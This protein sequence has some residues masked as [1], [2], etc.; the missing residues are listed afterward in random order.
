MAAT[1]W[2]LASAI[3][4]FFS[5][6]IT[7]PA[8]PSFIQTILRWSHDVYSELNELPHHLH[9][10]DV[11]PAGGFKVLFSPGTVSRPWF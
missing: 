3:D 9:E 4:P 11:G 10:L 5:E 6:L 2:A 8:S 7:Y 1:L